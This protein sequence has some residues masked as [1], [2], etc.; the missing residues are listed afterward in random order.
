MHRLMIL[1]LWG[2]FVATLSPSPATPQTAKPMPSVAEL[3]H[4]YREA[5]QENE[6]LRHENE[7]LRHEN[8]Q[9]RRELAATKQAIS[10]SQ[11]NQ[12]QAEPAQPKTYQEAITALTKIL[13]KDPK[14][15]QAHRNRGIAYAHTG[16]Y[17]EALADLNRAIALNDDDAEVYNQRGIVHYNLGRYQQAMANFNQAID[18]QP[19][20]AEFYN[21]RGFVHQK[22]GDYQHALRD[23]RKAQQLGFTD[24]SKVV[25]SL[26]AEVRQAQQRLQHAGFDPG[27]ADG[28]PGAAT[29]KALRAYQQAHKL[30]VTGKLDNRTK[31]AL[32]KSVASEDILSRFIDKPSPEYP[33]KARLRGWEGTVSLRVE[34]LPDGTIG[35]IKI[36]KSSGHDI[37]DTAA[38]N[39]LKQ[40]RHR[41]PSQPDQP[42]TTWTTLHF[43]FKLDN[44]ADS[45]R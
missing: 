12:P 22:R 34:M 26:R 23:F 19:Q 18:K 15:A 28:L 6:Q 8:E 35:T 14:D 36:A 5:L 38:R 11:P 7:Q 37:L 24:A 16:K 30:P 43:N 31:Q 4:Q 42:P 20:L 29:A 41:P 3:Q 25:Q 45:N 27:P 13:E 17:P 2:L 10:R 40:W 9:L 39:V 21:N 33:I 32:E 44:T 1:T